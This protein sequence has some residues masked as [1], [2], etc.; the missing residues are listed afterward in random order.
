MAKH[1]EILCVLPG[2]LAESE[3][4]AVV[5]VIK[6]GVEERGGTN[7][8]TEDAGK[9][10]LAY[11]MKNI[12]YGYFHFIRFE[13][14]PASLPG[15]QEK[16]RLVTDALR[17]IVQ[18]YDASRHS[19]LSQRMSA[20]QKFAAQDDTVRVTRKHRLEEEDEDQDDEEKKEKKTAPKITPT[21]AIEV[22]PKAEE[23]KEINIE[24]IDKKIDEILDSSIASL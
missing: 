19:A 11:P 14:E 21:V 8:V 15:I 4:P 2:T 12:R 5:E 17:L 18:E 10:R 23:K 20:L 9:T 1:Y 3:V 13:A 6:R 24:D 7:T 16:L 22:K